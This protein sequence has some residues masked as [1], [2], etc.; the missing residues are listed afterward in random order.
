MISTYQTDII[1]NDT[2]NDRQDTRK[3]PRIENERRYRT[4]LKLQTQYR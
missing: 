3:R 2:R 4:I 1:D